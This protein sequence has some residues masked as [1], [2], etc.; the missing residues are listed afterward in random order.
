MSRLALERSWPRG[1]RFCAAFARGIEIFVAMT[2]GDVRAATAIGREAMRIVAPLGD[3]FAVGTNTAQFALP[4]GMGGDI[5]AARKMMDPIVRSVDTAPDVD[6]VGFMVP[7]GLLHLWDGD[8]DGAVRWL[9][10]GVARMSGGARDWTAGRCLPGL[11]A[12]LRRSGRTDEAAEYAATAVAVET[13][14]G[15]PYELTNVLD[16]QARMLRHTDPGQSRDLHLHALGIRR[17][18]GLRTGYV[19]SLDALAY[20]SAD[21]GNH[22]ESVRL[23]ALSD[24]ARERIGYPR[25]PVELPEYEAV[26][27]EARDRLGAEQFDAVRR[28]GAARSLDDTVAALTRGRGP[29]NRPPVGWESL[30][31][32][33]LDVARLVSQGLSNPE[34]A[35]RLYVSRS[36]V[37][38]H[39]SHIY[40]KVGVANRT[41][42]AAIT[43]TELAPE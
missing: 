22:E 31:P 26:D 18:N 4:V 17:A 19:D 16:E 27:A 12:A 34:I 2:T 6:V 23:L 13:E 38:A 36:T 1:D 39:L 42:L 40:A 3:F 29:R 41:E 43:S 25:P 15:A 24:A 20:L 21:A 35:A 10:R 11:V 32:T 37:K 7:Y 33:E 14:F 8:L 30:T 9:R 5:A 28:E